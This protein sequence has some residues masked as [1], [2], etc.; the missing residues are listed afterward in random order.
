MS[1]KIEMNSV[2]S[3]LE[4][5]NSKKRVAGYTHDF[6]NYPARFSPLLVRELILNFSDEG[7]VI[8]D[9]FMGGGTTLIEA[10]LLNRNSFGFDISSLSSFLARVKSNPIKTNRFHFFDVWM[11]E[12]VDQLNC[13]ANSPRPHSWIEKGYQKHLNNRET[14]PIRKIIEQFLHELSLLDITE[15]ESDFVRCVILKT[16]QWALDSRRFI[17]KVDEFK[18]K[19]LENYQQMKKGAM[20]F[21]SE[22]PKAKAT[23][24]NCSANQI[25]NHSKLFKAKP[26]L[27]L[28]SPPYPGVHVVYH[29]WQVYGK[30]ETPAP[31]WIA[32]SSDGH[33]LTH[34]AMGGRKQKGLVDY[35]EN[36]KKSFESIKVICDQETVVVQILAFSE[37]EWQLP[38]YIETMEQAGYYEVSQEGRIWRDVPNRKWYASQ[39]GK[40]SS[41]K[42][43]ILFHKIAK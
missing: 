37:I 10:R 36:I 7:D 4:A 31:F 25:H 8:L 38:K 1:G 13:Q 22:K 29:R 43:V 15:N 5:A 11:N 42:E 2:S 41:S 24:V 26:K 18:G 34:Y 6:Y 19:L 28:T 33:G 27:V 12:T 16:G 20:D 32:N 40:T 9:P 30:K 23:I 21:W 3:V 39:K 14:W 17:P 35:F